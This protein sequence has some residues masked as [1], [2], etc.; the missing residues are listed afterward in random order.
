MTATSIHYVNAGAGSG[1]TH[2]LVGHAATL[3][4][5]QKAKVL[6]AQPTKVLILQTLAEIKSRF[7]DVTAQ[8]IYNTGDGKPI[9]P[10]IVEHMGQADRHNGQILLIT[11]EALKR[12]PNAYR[13]HWDLFVDEIPAVFENVSLRVAKTHNHLTD[14]LD[15][16]DIT[17]K[18]AAVKIREGSKSQMEARRV[19]KTGDQLLGLFGEIA[20]HLLDENRNVMVETAEFNALLNGKRPKGEL[21]F[22]SLLRAEVVADY[23]SVTLMGANATETEL[24]SYGK[25]SVRLSS[26]SIRN[27]PRGCASRSMTMAI[28]LPSIS[29][30]SMNGRFRAHD[31]WTRKRARRCSKR[32]GILCRTILRNGGF[33]GL[34]TRLRKCRCSIRT[35][36][37]LR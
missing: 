1:K 33:S 10:A 34:P 13:V 25:P 9:T 28:A 29:C 23:R 6:I 4:K 5:T 22:F 3:V 21:N 27:C 16:E 35:T 31:E 18:V 7:P 8:A 17:D 32:S 20:T 24:S 30:S 11:H 12:L 15:L 36:A 26:W 2:Q 19:N 37:C 14:L